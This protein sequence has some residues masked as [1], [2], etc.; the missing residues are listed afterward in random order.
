MPVLA[1]DL[2]DA[3]LQAAMEGK[4]TE[5]L[6]SESSVD[7]LLKNIQQEKELL[8][9][10]KKIKKEKS[11]APISDDEIP[12]DIP[13]NWRWCRLG[14]I[15]N[16]QIG[17]TPPRAESQWWGESKDVPWV[18]ISDMLP[19][20]VI[21]VTK[22]FVTQDCVKQKFN[23]R[24][25]PKGTMIMSFKL[26]IGRISIL[27][28]DAVHNEAIVSIY[29]FID[30]DNILQKYLSKILPFLT[31]FGDSKTAIKGKT[32][33]SKSLSNLL[34][35]LPPIE[36]QQR[37]VDKL[38]EIM[39]LIDEYEKLEHQL[40]ELKKKFTDDMKA[41]ISLSAF[42]GE[43]SDEYINVS[44]VEKLIDSISKIKDKKISQG[45][46]KKEKPLPKIKDNDIPYQIPN[47]WKWVRFGD[48]CEKVT[49]QVASGSF[50]ALRENVKSLKTEDYAIMVKIADFGNNFSKD[51]TYTDKHGYD[52]L[53][54]SNL[55]GG[56]LILSNIG[57]IGK[58]FI[59]PDLQRPMTLAPNSIMLRL[60]D[61]SLR[62]YIYRYLTSPV[63]YKQL[64]SITSGTAMKKFN[65]TD[66]KKLL[67]PI[68]PIEEQ[69]HIVDKLDQL[70]PLI[71]QLN[72][73]I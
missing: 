64:M 63:G 19:D 27:G 55:F 40:V 3:V 56:E 7:E 29:P 17:K 62:D 52:F 36:E 4:L 20:S 46:L 72:E 73:V 16:M 8:I 58:V 25:S 61:N 44:S 50:K 45:E 67:I 28:M 35:P 65:K 1:Q 15:V 22:E 41:A 21:T 38:N 43:L 24:I 57:S 48:Y 69:Q 71:D 34:L 26:T 49:D 31:Q 37:I 47:H 54:N 10:E 70:L 30:K 12:F 14:N 66:F 11:L 32:L 23:G 53:K 6:E 13:D 18:S 68:P 60:T 2:R 42:K 5:Q 9:K 39:P 51:L 33:N 59:V